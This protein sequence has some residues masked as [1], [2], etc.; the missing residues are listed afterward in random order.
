MNTNLNE[1]TDA[2]KILVECLIEELS[3]NDLIN[4]TSLNTRINERV[5]NIIYTDFIQQIQKNVN[6]TPKSFLNTNIIG[7]S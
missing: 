2:L 6:S 3:D 1:T 7:D 5:K 4:K